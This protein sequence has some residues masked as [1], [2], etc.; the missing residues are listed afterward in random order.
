MGFEPGPML[1]AVAL[2]ASCGFMLPVSTP[3]NAIVF[4]TG[5]LTIMDMVKA[6][7]WINLASAAVITLYTWLL[8]PRLLPGV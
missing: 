8:G 7:L 1:L 6:G 5:R 4:S 2:T 3:P